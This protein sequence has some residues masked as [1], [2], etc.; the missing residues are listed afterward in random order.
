[1]NPHA[2]LGH[3]LAAVLLL[4]GAASAD[5]GG[6]RGRT[7]LEVGCRKQLLVDER[8]IE[9]AENVV[10]TMNPPAKA[11]PVL[12]PDRPWESAELGFGLSIVDGADRKEMWYWGEP[13]SGEVLLCLA[14]S[15]D[16]V[17]W[18]KPNLGL[19]D[20]EGSTANNIVYRALGEKFV[21]RD[22][23]APAHQRYKMVL[24]NAQGGRDPRPKGMYAAYSA[25]GLRWSD[26]V[27]VLPVEPDTITEFF[28]DA[29]LGKYVI[30]TRLWNPLR[31]VGRIESGDVLAPWPVRA[32]R[33][34]SSDPAAYLLAV[35]G[36]S[37]RDAFDKN[38][39]DPETAPLMD[40]A[41]GTDALDPPGLDHYHAAV[42]PYPAA[43]DAYFMFPAAFL[44]APDDAMLGPVDAQMA[45]SRDGLR[46]RRVDPR[47]YLRLGP[48]GARD[49]GQI[50]MGIGAVAAGDEIF[51]Y[52]AGYAQLHG[53]GR[54]YGAGHMDR[55][56]GIFRAVQRR[57]GFVS[58]DAGY[59]GGFLL[60]PALVHRGTRLELN[61]DTSAAGVA[62]VAI[63]DREGKPLPGYAAEDC[64]PISG[65]FVRKTVSWHGRDDLGALAGRPV[66]LRFVMRSAKLF[67]FQFVGSDGR[68]CD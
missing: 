35:E 44:H 49:G 40:E 30:Y 48:S 56:G 4:A 54:R 27:R 55:W 39:G 15:S 51:Q 41:F 67:A 18:T 11:G 13:R 10:L 63:E 61:V 9:R 57:D 32:Y 21:Y 31:R 33:K 45:V 16:G 50:Y 62:R 59:A 17:S 12:L 6:E 22:A 53:E 24:R 28:F 2:K 46:F 23:A 38:A 34:R 20:F 64:D 52:Y 8:F 1:M 29:R 37:G 7:P 25:D 58:A 68:A 43:Q 66:R 3:E 60:T 42:L 47:P 14:T 5:A 65:N 36:R 19:V 26:P